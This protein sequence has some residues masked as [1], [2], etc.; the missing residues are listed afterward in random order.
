MA[1]AGSSP[2]R[3]LWIVCPVF[4]DVPSW[5]VLRQRLD[6]L[7]DA[8]SAFRGLERRFVVFD[9]SAG[10]D[11]EIERISPSPEVMVVTPPRN[12]GN[13]RAIVAA[14]REV[15]AEVHDH[16]LI[17]TMDA[18]GEDAP[19][20]VSKL[21]SELDRPAS[22]PMRVVLAKRTGR[23]RGAL[24]MQLFYPGY[25][26]LF[27]LL[28]GFKTATGNFAAFSGSTAK[29]MIEL[30]VFDQV[31]SAG[32]ISSDALSRT[33]VPC[34][35]GA[36]YEGR[37]KIG[38]IQHCRHAFWMLLPFRDEVSRRLSLFSLAIITG[39]GILLRVPSLGAPLFGDELSTYFIVEGHSLRE[40]LAIVKGPQ[41]ATP[42]LYFAAALIFSQLGDSPYLL[43][44]PS[45][46]AGVSLIPLTWLLGVRTVGRGPGLVA[47]ALVASSPLMVFY[48]TEARA[49]AAAAF[50]ALCSTLVLVSLSRKSSIP[51]WAL[52]AVLIALAM[53]SHYT[54]VFVLAAQ[55][56]WA[57]VVLKDLRGRLA[58][59]VTGAFLLFLPWF[60]GFLAESSSAGSLLIEY[61]FPCDAETFAIFTS[62]WIFGN[63]VTAEFELVNG[64]P[65]AVVFCLALVIAAGD[66]LSRGNVRPNRYQTLIL[67][68][69]IAAPL[70]AALYSLLAPSVFLPRNL[71]SS[72]PG[73]ALFSG[74]VVCA[75]RPRLRA[76]LVIVVIGA[77]ALGGVRSVTA[78]QRRPDYSRIVS[79][80]ETRGTTGDPVVDLP[81]ITSGALQGLEVEFRASR[82]GRSSTD[83]PVYRIGMPTIRQLTKDGQVPGLV[84]P[85]PVPD[86]ERVAARASARSGSGRLFLVVRHGVAPDRLGKPGTPD[87]DLLRKFLLGLPA[88][89]RIVSDLR[90]SG[91]VSTRLAVYEIR[92]GAKR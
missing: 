57:F 87:A 55:T 18:D 52:Y 35:K 15:V 26:V 68:L 3:K 90:T 43:R 80:I 34:P 92:V 6:E 78:D 51:R 46:V 67:I 32:L 22:E 71:I 9:D 10:F 7:L 30:P 4:H 56:L 40:A 39:A 28:T 21:L 83:F 77:M 14:V 70:G 36:R 20:D 53:Y 72:W 25:R 1:G 12:L 75:A 23:R 11:P 81:Y 19:E 65:A 24:S 82:G 13:Q 48:S 29:A 27:R 73:L 61:R 45:L 38:F 60:P 58:L 84:R 41:E 88:D 79:F 50:F 44:I 47:A 42:P 54:A 2:A 63:G 33:Y 66:R 69:A 17:V 91:V 37:P 89:S 49:Y 64:T 16:D 8:D 85:L 76:I 5:T 62:N 59:A 74:M 31:W 86:P